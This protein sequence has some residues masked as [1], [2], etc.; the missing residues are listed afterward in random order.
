MSRILYGL[1][2]KLSYVYFFIDS[3]SIFVEKNNDYPLGNVIL[4]DWE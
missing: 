2:A 1:H 4:Y 3:I